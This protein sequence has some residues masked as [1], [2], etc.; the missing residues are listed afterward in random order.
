[1]CRTRMYT[2]LCSDEYNA[3][4][5][6]MIDEDPEC[7]IIVATIAFSNGINAKSIL[8]SISL[9]FS[10]TRD[11]VV[12]EKGRAGRAE[13]SLARGVVLVQPATIAAAKKQRQVAAPPAIPSN[14]AAPKKITS[15]KNQRKPSA[16]MAPEK[17][18]ILVEE[19]W[20][21]AFFNRHYSNPP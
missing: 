12:Q 3:E 10:S 20:Y 1:M 16:P 17:A 14:T 21:I 9:G 8:D 6:R 7:Q 4:T 11:I 2:S 13:G 19:I 18:S 5:L 15:K